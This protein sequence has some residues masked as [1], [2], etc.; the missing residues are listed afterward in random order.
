MQFSAFKEMIL[1]PQPTPK[2]SSLDLV[3]PINFFTWFQRQGYWVRCGGPRTV[4][5]GR[6]CEY[7][8]IHECALFGLEKGFGHE[9]LH[10]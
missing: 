6:S 8:P 3:W 7:I 5:D 10:C 1:G 4:R 9:I 2:A